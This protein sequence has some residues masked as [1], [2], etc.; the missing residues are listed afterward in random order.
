MNSQLSLLFLH[1]PFGRACLL[2]NFD[3]VILVVFSVP[4]PGDSR[5]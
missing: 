1:V 5:G 4:E 3:V 2:G